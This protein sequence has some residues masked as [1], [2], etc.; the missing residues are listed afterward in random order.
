MIKLGNKQ[1]EKTNLGRNI[2]HVII[3]IA[4]SFVMLKINPEIG[5]NN[6]LDL[7]KLLELNIILLG[8]GI[9]LITFV[10]SVIMNLKKTFYEKSEIIVS[11]DD[12][13]KVMKSISLNIWRLLFSLLLIIIILFCKDINIPYLFLCGYKAYVLSAVRLAIFLYIIIALI[14]VV[15]STLKLYE[16]DLSNYKP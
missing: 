8:V 13:A 12:F 10:Y 15:V 11:D 1:K 7:E 3:L 2:F 6:L 16:F 9:S 5:T 14:D 4:F